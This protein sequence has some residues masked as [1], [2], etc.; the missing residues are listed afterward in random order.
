MTANEPDASLP[1]ELGQD[2]ESPFTLGLLL[3]QAHDRVLGAMDV[4]LKPLGIERRHLVVLMRLSTEGPL[5]QRDLVARTQHDKAAIVRIVDDL[6]RFGLASRQPVPGDRRLWAVTMTDQGQ[7][8]YE[9]ARQAAMPA[10]ARTT[11]NLSADQVEQLKGLLR[12][13]VRG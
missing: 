13:I 6:E 9:Q 3:R 8:V 1:A 2:D 4:V 5:P 11:A 12:A 7:R 10:A